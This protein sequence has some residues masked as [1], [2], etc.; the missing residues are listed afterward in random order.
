[1]ILN[2]DLGNKLGMAKALMGFGELALAQNDP[3]RSV[4]L[5][6]AAEALRQTIGAPMPATE[7]TRF[8]SDVARVQ[9]LLEKETFAA[10][11]NAGKKMTDEEAVSYALKEKWRISNSMLHR[12]SGQS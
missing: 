2:R 12:A 9:A 11:W 4:R 8:E 3:E 5:F 7:R 10:A 6:A 1:M